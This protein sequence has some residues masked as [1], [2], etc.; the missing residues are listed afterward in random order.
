MGPTTEAT[1]PALSARD[2]LAKS[3]PLTFLAF[4]I[5]MA[6]SLITGM[7]LMTSATISAASPGSR[8]TI[9]I[10]LNNFSRPRVI[11]LGDVV[12][13]KSDETRIMSKSCE[14]TVTPLCNP[15]LVMLT[16]QIGKG[17]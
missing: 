15:W 8:P 12:S 4:T 1:L 6:S 5:F 3:T 17:G 7:N 16:P 14:K 11:S 2:P 9:L 10:G 13:V